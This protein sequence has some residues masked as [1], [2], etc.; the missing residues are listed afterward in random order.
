MHQDIIKHYQDFPIP[1]IDFIDVVPF[2][3]NREAF[4]SLIHDIDK[5]ITTPNVATVEARGFFFAAPLLTE[6]KSVANIIP[7][8]KKGK[9]PFA[10]GDLHD[11]AITKE[12]GQDHVF[13]RISDIAAGVPATVTDGSEADPDTIYLTFFDDILATGGTSY[14]IADQLNHETVTID[15]KVYKVKVKEFVFLVE[16]ASEIPGA[17]ARLEKLAPVRS[18]IK[19]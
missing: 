17:A 18:I 12:Y 6:S 9:L 13:Y 1:G 8:R 7:I 19:L 5:A 10:E 15:G 3:Q 2:L 14:G 16:L 4:K 11:V